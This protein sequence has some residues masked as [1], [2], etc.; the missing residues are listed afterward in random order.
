[1]KQ[2]VYSSEKHPNCKSTSDFHFNF[3]GIWKSLLRS[4]SMSGKY[5][6]ISGCQ[7]S[8]R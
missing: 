8:K 1:M 6:E 4:T 2:A 3:R 5:L 7:D